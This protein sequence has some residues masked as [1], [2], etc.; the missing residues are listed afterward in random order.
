MEKMFRVRITEDGCS[1]IDEMTGMSIDTVYF[2]TYAD[3]CEAVAIVKHAFTG[4][5]YSERIIPD[6]DIFKREKIIREFNRRWNIATIMGNS[7][8]YME[9]PQPNSKSIN[10][11]DPYKIYLDKVEPGDTIY[12]NSEHGDI[13]NHEPFGYVQLKNCIKYYGPIEGDSASPNMHLV[14]CE[15]VSKLPEEFD[16]QLFLGKDGFLYKT[17]VEVG[18]KDEQIGDFLKR[19]KTLRKRLHRLNII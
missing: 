6:R 5:R 18:W 16:Y 4:N 9:T 14:L 3:C 7:I 17:M 11:S 8:A 19:H 12:T 13:L 2:G 15:K 1:K 10:E